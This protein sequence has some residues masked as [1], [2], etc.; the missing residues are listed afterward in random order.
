MT[1]LE[2]WTS[3]KGISVAGSEE[4]SELYNTLNFGAPL[5]SVGTAIV[6]ATETSRTGIQNIILMA[7]VVLLDIP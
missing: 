3:I 6:V 2:N 1:P 5:L 7:Y 4:S